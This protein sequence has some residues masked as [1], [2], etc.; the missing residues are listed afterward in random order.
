MP[1]SDPQP[2]ELED[3]LPR[4]YVIQCKGESPFAPPSI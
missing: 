4:W 3:S 2:N 1:H